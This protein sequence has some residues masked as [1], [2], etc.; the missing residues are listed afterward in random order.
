MTPRLKFGVVFSSMLLTVMLV[1]GAVV[2]KSKD[3][4]G[5]YRPLAVYTEVLAKIKSEYVEEPDMKKVT[6]GALQGLVEYL[7]PE[8]SYL[9]AEQYKVYQDAKKNPDGGSGLA[10]GL[11]VQKRAGYA[12]VAAVLPDS[13]AQK[14]GIETFDLIEAIDGLSTRVMPPAYLHAMLSGPPGTSV[15]LLIRP[16]RNADEPKEHTLGR[17]PVMLPAATNRL[18]EA[19]VGYIDVDALAGQQLQQIGEALKALQSQGVTKLVLD[20]RDCAI[21]EPA[22]G[23]AL[24]NYFVDKGN[25]ATLKGQRYPEKVFPADPASAVWS[26]Q[27][28]VLTDRSTTGGAEVA[29]AAIL[30]LKR[31]DVVGERTGGLAALQETLELEDGAALILSVAKYHRPAGEALHD[32]GLT[33]NHPLSPAEL[34]RYRSNLSE[35]DFGEPLPA[36]PEPAPPTTEDGDPFLK[37]ALEVLQGKAAAKAA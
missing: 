6:R 5:A 19:G 36:L 29:A 13:P 32:N 25:V 34:R 30:D 15:Q 12:H 11:V 35:D 26:G 9:T 4:E 22:D 3:P 23:L 10:T 7:D 2:G 33:P 37:K 14:A 17:A 1:I 21:G 18:L 20:L 16:A 27:V 8:S 28:V 31:G 24:A